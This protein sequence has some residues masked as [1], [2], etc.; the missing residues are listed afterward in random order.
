[1]KYSE[2]ITTIQSSPIRKLAPLANIAKDN[3]YQDS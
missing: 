2:R 1:M 3:G